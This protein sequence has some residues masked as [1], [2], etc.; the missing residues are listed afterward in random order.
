MVAASSNQCATCGATL[1]S[2]QR[3]CLACGERRG[4]ARFSLSAPAAAA[5]QPP[6]TSRREQRGARLASGTAFILGVGTLLLAVGVGVLIGHTNNAPATPQASKTPVQVITV[7][8]GGGSGGAAGKSSGS[9]KGSKRAGHKAAAKQKPAISKQ[10]AAKAQAAAAKVLGTSA[11]NVPP[12]TVTVGQK[13][14]GPGFTNG[15]FTGTFFGQ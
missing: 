4:K 10:V 5:A 7:A 2:D 1:A 12:P 14:H 8:G 9:S 15:H 13:G 11:K 3:Y 6:A